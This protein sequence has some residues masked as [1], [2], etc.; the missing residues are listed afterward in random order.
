VSSASGWLWVLE[1]ARLV[2]VG[3]FAVHRCSV[4]SD[5]LRAELEQ[6]PCCHLHCGCWDLISASFISDVLVHVLVAPPVMSLNL[7]TS[8]VKNQHVLGSK[9]DHMGL[10]CDDVASRRRLGFPEAVRS[11]CRPR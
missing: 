11:N 3:E 7:D 8:R 10:R 4:G 5:P 2:A 6:E 9:N 1:H